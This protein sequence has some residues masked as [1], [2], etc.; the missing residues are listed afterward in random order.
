MELSLAFRKPFFSD[1]SLILHSLA[2]YVS[3]YT[4][5]CPYTLFYNLSL[6][7]IC[8]LI[9]SYS[10]ALISSILYLLTALPYLL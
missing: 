2:I 3:I 7:Y 4:V 9:K 1:H 5:L 10:K 8:S 6:V